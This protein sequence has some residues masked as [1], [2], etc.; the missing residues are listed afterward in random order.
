MTMSSES[1]RCNH[2]L[3]VSCVCP[4]PRC[5]RGVT[6]GS[7]SAGACGVVRKSVCNGRLWGS[8]EEAVRQAPTGQLEQIGTTGTCKP[9]R[10]SRNNGGL[11]GNEEESVQTGAF[12][13]VRKRRCNKRMW[14]GESEVC[15]AARA[16]QSIGRRWGSLDSESAVCVQRLSVNVV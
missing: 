1:A 15:G 13:A 14:G 5:Q 9:V 11:W 7:E 4:E 8:E 2:G 3:R 12:G 10:G 16:R 6:L